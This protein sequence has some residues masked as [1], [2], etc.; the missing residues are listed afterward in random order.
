MSFDKEKYWERRALG[1][2]GQG[3]HPK[4]GI[5]VGAYGPLDWQ[6]LNEAKATH[7]GGGPRELRRR[8]ETLAKNRAGKRGAK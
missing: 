4:R 5:V 2:R 8:V 1:Q 7:Y 6:K 3:P